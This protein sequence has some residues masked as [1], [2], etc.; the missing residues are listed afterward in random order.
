MSRFI[1][2][3]LDCSEL[4]NHENQ[5]EAIEKI[6]HKYELE[7]RA[8]IKMEKEFKRIAQEAEKKYEDLKADHLTINRKYTEVIQKLSNFASENEHL[9]KEN[10]ELKT[11]FVEITSFDDTHGLKIKKKSAK[12]I[13]K[14]KPLLHYNPS[15]YIKLTSTNKKVF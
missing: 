14:T 13:D 15:N 2:D 4:S 10:E 6:L 11:L 3:L 9:T 8:H 1:S 12:S 7:I 5:N